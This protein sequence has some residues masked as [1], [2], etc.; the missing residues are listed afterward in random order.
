MQLLRRRHVEAVAL[1]FA[2]SAAARCDGVDLRYSRQISGGGQGEWVLIVTQIV[3]LLN[4]CVSDWSSDTVLTK[5]AHE[6]TAT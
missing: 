5:N 3:Y 4:L 1:V 2:A 6:F